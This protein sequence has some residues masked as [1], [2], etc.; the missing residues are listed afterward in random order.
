MDRALLS[1]AQ[2]ADLARR[3]AE[4]RQTTVNQKCA[5][6]HPR[7]SFYTR[8]VKRAIDIA[9][10]ILALTV[11]LPIN[12]V[13]GVITYF[14]VGRPIFFT[15]DRIGKDGKLFKIVNLRWMKII[16]GVHR[17]YAVN[18]PTFCAA[19]TTK[20]SECDFRHRCGSLKLIA[21]V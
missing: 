19:R 5:S 4:E 2:R 12:L 16:D 9:V 3:L 20:R 7:V 13:I 1:K 8:F 15:Q 6:V 21:A 17:E 14:D 11:T 18:L 10:S